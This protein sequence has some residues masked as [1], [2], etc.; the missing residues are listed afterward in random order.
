[1]ITLCECDCMK[2]GEIRERERIIK[3]LETEF[4]KGNEHICQNCDT[5]LEIKGEQ[6]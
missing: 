1:M 4:E 5:W 2:S 3:L 6:K